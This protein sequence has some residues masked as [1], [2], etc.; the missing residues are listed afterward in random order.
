MDLKS[1]SILVTVAVDPSALHSF[2]SV[3]GLEQN[4]GPVPSLRLADRHSTIDHEQSL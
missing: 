2:A 4:I 1:S 3:V